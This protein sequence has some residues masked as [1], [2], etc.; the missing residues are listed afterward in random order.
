MKHPIHGFFPILFVVLVLT[1]CAGKRSRVNDPTDVRDY[2]ESAAK[3]RVEAEAGEGS[4]W[5]GNGYR[6]NLFRDLKARYINDVLTIRVSETTQA[7]A[8]A[9]A[10]NSRSTSAT[11]G[12]NNL[13]GMEKGIKELPTLV[14]GKSDSSFDG[15]GSTSRA[16]TLETTLTARVIDVLPNGYLVVEGKREIRVNNESQS[17]YL[18]GVVRPEDINQ[19]NVVSSAS[20]AQMSVRVQ[21]RGVVSQ[22]I[23]PGWLYRILTGVLPF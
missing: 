7:V 9:D 6:A 15:K 2:V 3:S 17:V 1:G 12:F 22:P 11:A 10:K 16:T 14:S 19:N 18:T 4:L 5:V 23:K 21:G 13:F 20:V 8:S